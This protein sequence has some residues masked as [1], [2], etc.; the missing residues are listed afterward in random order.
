MDEELN[1]IEHIGGFRVGDVLR[2]LDNAKYGL[3]SIVKIIELFAKTH[4]DKH[5]DIHHGY[6]FRVVSPSDTE[7]V[8]KEE[9]LAYLEV[10]CDPLTI[11][12]LFGK[13]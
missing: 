10:V 2:I 3:P 8:L 4:Y 6:Y 7:W 12:I 1:R 5:G 9:A 13:K 11:V